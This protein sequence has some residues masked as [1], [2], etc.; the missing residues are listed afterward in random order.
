VAAYSPWTV[1][2]SALLL[3]AQ[4]QSSIQ[5]PPSPEPEEAEL[6][7][8]DGSV[9]RA[10]ILQD[11][12][13]VMTRYGKLSVPAREIRHIEFGVHLPPGIEQRVAAAIRE[14]ASEQYKNREAAV[15]DLVALGPHAYPALHQ[16]AKST[17]L[18]VAQRVEIALKRIRAKIH[19][20]HL[21]LREDDL[22]LTPA[23]TIVGRILT[24]TIQARAENFGDLSVRV[25]QLRVIRM[26]GGGREV[27]V[28]VDAAKH[29]AN[30][31]HWLDTGFEV[32]SNTRLLVSAVGQIDLW[33]QGPGQYLCGP[34]GYGAAGRGV[35][36]NRV[37]LGNGPGLAAVGQYPGALL[38]RVGDNGPIFLLGEHFQ[39]TPGREGRL[40][41]QIGPN[42]WNNPSQGTFQVRIVPN[43]DLDG[44]GD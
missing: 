21:R 10:V 36:G 23:F 26:M 14:L 28:V 22:I 7:Y 27:D 35:G 42:P 44:V 8:A 3:I 20:K 24:P 5:Q 1:I 15:R 16:A 37:V 17:D 11:R 29:S 33:P 40:F 32:Q 9:I 19:P 18:E 41:L 39:G 4:P 2:A 31:G 25:S 6:R 13:E 34:Q 12:L 38:G 30:G 43:R